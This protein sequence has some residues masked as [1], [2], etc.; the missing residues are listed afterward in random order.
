MEVT[1][2]RVYHDGLKKLNF[3][4]AKFNYY[5]KDIWLYLLATQWLSIAQEEAF[6]ARCG[7]AGDELGSQLIASSMIQKLMKLCFLM[8]RQYAPYSKWFGKAFARL[9]CSKQLHPNNQFKA[10]YGKK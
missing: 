9:S 8:E 4:R 10:M 2:G 7:D 5:P 3:V 6:M 1:S